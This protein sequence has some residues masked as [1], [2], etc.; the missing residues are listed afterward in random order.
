MSWFQVESSDDKQITVFFVPSPHRY[1]LPEVLRQS[2]LADKDLARRAVTLTGPGAVWM[3]AHAAAVARASNAAD[4]AVDSKPKRDGRQEVLAEDYRYIQDDLHGAVLNFHLTRTLAESAL[5]QILQQASADLRAHRP[6]G[7]VLAGLA[8]VHLYAKLA[9]EAVGLGVQRLA[10]F[11]VRDGLVE[12][13]LSPAA[14]SG[15]PSNWEWAEPYLYRKQPG[16]ALGILGDPNRGK[17]LFARVLDEFRASWKGQEAL[18][19][20]LLDCDGQAPTPPWF[21]DFRQVN[22]QEAAQMRQQYKR[23]WTPEM[24]RLITEHIQ[25]ARRLFE[26]LIADLPGGN[27]SVQPPDRIPAS[28]ASMFQAVDAFVL[29][30]GDQPEHEEAGWRQALA[31]H[32][33]ESR[34]VA[35]VHSTDPSGPLSLRAGRP[36]PAGCWRGVVTGLD[37][38]KQADQI[39]QDLKGG[40]SA[41]WTHLRAALPLQPA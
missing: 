12:V 11:S 23:P 10:C 31:G 22:P 20:W 27:H 13:Y 4:L 8:P 9:W 33:L 30:V 24:E 15:P 35:V 26:V 40:L 18:S 29:L 5:Q 34:L 1:W 36:H 21:R 25:R 3:Y 19:G 7:L 2:P 38:Q 14:R 32:G 37:R 6:L 39:F 16:R 28:R 41:L 17:S